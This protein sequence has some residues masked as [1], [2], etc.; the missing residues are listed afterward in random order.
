[1][2]LFYLKIG[3]QQY[4]S[5]AWKVKNIILLTIFDV[6]IFVG[7]YKNKNKVDFSV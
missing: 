1:M 6:M 2:S 7:Q 3:I 4:T 5:Y